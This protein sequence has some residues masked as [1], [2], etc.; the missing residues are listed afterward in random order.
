MLGFLRI[1]VYILLGLSLTPAKNGNDKEETS[2]NSFTDKE[3]LKIN[4]YLAVSNI[5]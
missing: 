5:E 2:T 1:H 4:Y 3:I